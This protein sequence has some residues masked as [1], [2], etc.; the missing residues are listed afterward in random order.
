MT[1]ATTAVVL[2]CDATYLPF[3]LHLARQ[4]L[5]HCPHRKFDLLIASE[6]PLPFP[7]WAVSSGIRPLVIGQARWI[8][9]VKLRHL[10]RVTYLRLCL[11]DVMGDQYARILY[12]DGDMFF[13]GGD[14][15]RLLALPMAG[16]PVAAVTDIDQFYNPAFHAR[17]FRA[18]GLPP[19]RYFNAGVLLMNSDAYRNHAVFPRALDLAKNRPEAHILHDQSLL[20]GVLQGEFAELAPVWNWQSSAHLPYATLTYPVRFRHFVGRVKPWADVRGVFDPRYH[21]GYVDFFRTLMPEAMSHVQS[22]PKPQLADL[23]FLVRRLIIHARR[24]KVVGA[25]LARFVDEW[26]IKL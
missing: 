14:L 6:S 12:L 13:E 11:P 3:T 8:D 22:R 7:D 25:A 16:H 2:C 5:H 4:I 1:D 20:N 24:R 21:A 19:L 18:L 10:P 23:E 26:D 15:D 17:E 9:G